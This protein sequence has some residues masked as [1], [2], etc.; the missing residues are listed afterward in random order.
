MLLKNANIFTNDF[1]F[2]KGS[3]S[4]EEQDISCLDFDDTSKYLFNQDVIDCTDLYAIPGFIDLHF[5]GA[6]GRDVS[7]GNASDVLEIAKYEAS[8][9]IL[10]LC[11]ATMTLSE[12]KLTKAMSSLNSYKNDTPKDRCADLL[13]INLE[14]PFLSKQRLGAQNPKY[15]H[16]PDFDM[17]KR[18]D[19]ASGGLIKIVCISPEVEGADDFIQKA[20]DKYTI[21]VAHTNATYKQTNNAIKL[22][23]KHLTHMFNAMPQIT[24]RSPGPIISFSEASLNDPGCVHTELICD[25]H[26]IDSPMIRFAFRLIDKNSIVMISDSSEATG[27]PDGQYSLGGLDIIK[28]N[29][30]ATLKDDTNTIAGSVSN[31]YDCFK[32]AVRCAKVP[33][34]LAVMACT[35]NPAR[36]IGVE[37]SYGSIEVGKKANILLIDKD[38][39]IRNIILRGRV[40]K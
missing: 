12:D 36:A 38:L 6:V 21:S 7:D 9:G 33:L 10:G 23:A 17:L 27:M 29:N 13:G 4:I 26:H 22:G 31:L 40:I 18:L 34:N 8:C 35:I 25:G 30:I 5:H 15:V 32:Y 16:V 2:K 14:G 37:R 24:H 1:D 28:M 3:I 11:P 39:K 20:C 19:E